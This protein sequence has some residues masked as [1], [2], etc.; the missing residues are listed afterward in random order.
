MISELTITDIA[1]QIVAEYEDY[2]EAGWKYIMSLRNAVD[3]FGRTD[4]AKME[5]YEA[6]ANQIGRSIK[7]LQN[8]VSFGFVV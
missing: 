3:Q 7:T 5:L 6:V 2:R 4:H 1:G 8:K